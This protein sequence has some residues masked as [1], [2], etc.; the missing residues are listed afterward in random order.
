MNNTKRSIASSCGLVFAAA[1]WGFAFVIVKDSLD[2]IGAVWMVAFRFTIAAVLLCFLFLRQLSQLTRRMVVHGA[3]LGV[4]IFF[5][6]F[7]Q[8]IGCKYTTAGKNAF[9]TTT[10]VVLV[11]LL[12]WPIY[13]KRPTWYVFVAAVLCMAGIGLLSLGGAPVIR[14]GAYGATHTVSMNKGDVLTLVCGVFYGVH[15]ICISHFTKTENPVLLTAVQFCCT[16]VCGW[17]AAP[18]C[19]GPIPLEALVTRRVAFSLLY[20]GVFSTLLAYLLQNIGLAYVPSALGSLFMSL[21]SVF[22]VFFSALFLSERLTPRMW[23]GCA[24][25]FVAILLAEVVPQLKKT[26]RP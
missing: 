10:Y 24:F 22:G 8:T 17:I 15:I 18:L 16:A 23:I 19:D 7:F 13:K 20:L 4:L 3:V 26:H 9:L 5:A 14:G 21:E 1:V 2:Y 12:C 25:I 6:Y 11:P